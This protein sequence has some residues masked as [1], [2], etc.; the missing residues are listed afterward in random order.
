MTDQ[1]IEKDTPSNTPLTAEEI[2]A[3]R[4]MP[5]DELMKSLAGKSAAEIYQL[6]TEVI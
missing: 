2:K 3:Y 1:A 6:M 5:S 4:E